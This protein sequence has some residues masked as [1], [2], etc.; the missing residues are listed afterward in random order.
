MQEHSTR[1]PENQAKKLS[2]Q[3]INVFG[4]SVILV[5][6]VIMIAVLLRVMSILDSTWQQIL[7][8]VVIIA[9]FATIAFA[10]LGL[11]KGST[12]LGA[13]MK[14]LSNLFGREIKSSGKE[15]SIGDA[16]N[17]KSEG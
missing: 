5:T 11:V 8:S 14:I 17:D 4:W 10:L 15:S 12:A 7:A 9:L 13:I 3:L 6:G 16:D 1:I 2:P